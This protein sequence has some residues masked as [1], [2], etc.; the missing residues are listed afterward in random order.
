M[1]RIRASGLFSD[2]PAKVSPHDQ[3]P[4]MEVYISTM[5]ANMKDL[6]RSS[7]EDP[8]DTIDQKV[9]KLVH[10]IQVFHRH[11]R[12]ISDD[13]T[14]RVHS[15]DLAELLFQPS[16]SYTSSRRDV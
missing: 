9:D 12:P 2:Q 13:L 4:R 14:S 8:R 3:K 15:I 16:R 10:S 6:I 5:Q 7:R 1:E 11:V